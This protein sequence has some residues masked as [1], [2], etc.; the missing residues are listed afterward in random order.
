MRRVPALNLAQLEAMAT[1]GLFGECFGLERREAL[2]AVGAVAQSRPGPPGRRRH[3]GRRR[4]RLPGMSP[5]EEAV[6]DLWAT[7]V[8][9]DGHPT[10]FLRAAARR[11]RR[12]DVAG[13]VG[14]RRPGHGSPS[15]ASSPTASAR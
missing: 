7:G 1:A 15:P 10:Q 13:A 8:A 14:R 12:R 4:R 5:V 9:P 11:A 3:R 2:W 6:A